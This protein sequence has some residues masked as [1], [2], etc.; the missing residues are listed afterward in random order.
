MASTRS[1]EPIILDDYIIPVTI[2]KEFRRSIRFS[3]TRKGLVIRCPVLSSTSNISE[4]AT[5]WCNNVIKTKPAAVAEFR[6]IDYFSTDHID[7][8][9]NRYTLNI[10]KSLTS[11]DSISWI[12]NIINITISDEYPTHLASKSIKD[13]IIKFAIRRFTPVIEERVRS[14]NERLFNVH[15][16]KVRLK[17]NRT[18][19]GSCS[20]RGNINL[21]VRLLKAPEETIDYVIIHELAHRIEMNHSKRFWNI[22][23]QVCPSYKS[24]EK[25]LKTN[26]H[27]CQF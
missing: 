6:I 18:N 1:L 23:A 22:I 11:R 9:G 25:W 20:S 27:L 21:S 15:I 17:N 16:N 2:H 5:K 14:L 26:G 19:W 4:N 7:L 8:L 12:D 3:I 24:H 10:T 13:L